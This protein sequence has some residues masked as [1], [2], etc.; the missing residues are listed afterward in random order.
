MSSEERFVLMLDEIKFNELCKKINSCTNCQLSKTRINVVPGEGDI[1]SPLMFIGE[2]PGADEDSQGRPFVGRAG[3]LL[4]KILESVQ[5]KREEVYIT[6]IVKCRPPNNRVPLPEEVKACQ[7]Y[8]FEQI[9]LIK[10]KIICALGSTSA[11]FL[12]GPDVGTISK[13]RGTWFD[14]KDGIKI[15][16]LYHPSYLL[17]NPSKEPGL[18][19]HQMWIDIQNV[20]ETYEK[21]RNMA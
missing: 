12:L 3:Q 10:P 8:L 13:I 14:Y 9:N 7:N 20:K 5:I 16:P 4:T 6:N 2:G 17:R 19:K 15:M 18:P 1:N 11:K 21:L